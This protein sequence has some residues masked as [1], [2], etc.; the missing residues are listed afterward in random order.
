MSHYRFFYM[1][2]CYLCHQCIEV[3]VINILDLDTNFQHN[4]VQHQIIVK[5]I[6]RGFRLRL[7]L[8]L[9]IDK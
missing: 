1:E 7:S 2:T 5:Q 9:Q 8:Q 6:M 3:P 4:M